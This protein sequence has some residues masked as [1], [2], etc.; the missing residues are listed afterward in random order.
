MAKFY[1]GLIS[2]HGNLMAAVDLET[3]GS[4]VG[5]HEIIQVAVQPLNSD[6]EPVY[7]PFYM[8]VA[9]K[10]PERADKEATHVHG[11]NIYKLEQEAL[12]AEKVADM[13]VEW[14]EGLDLAYGKRLVPL[15]HNWAF[16]SCFLSDWL[17]EKCK[18]LIF[19]VHPRDS[20]LYAISVNDR[21]CFLG[22]T[23]PFNSVGLGSLCLNLGIVNERPHDALADAR[24]EALL[25]RQLLRY[26]I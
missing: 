13:L 3:T 11:L 15:A 9:P 4:R 8:D 14:Y 17:G 25:Y 16:E 2:L 20:M 22:E 7:R 12:P 19:H 23:P 18:N 24:A 21:A 6:L 10:Y 1:S 26:E 5:Y